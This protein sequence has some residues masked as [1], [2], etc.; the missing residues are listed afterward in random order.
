MASST[1]PP[2]FVK[3]TKSIS[4]YDATSSSSTLG[5][6]D[7]DQDKNQTQP[8]MRHNGDLT[9]HDPPLFVLCTWVAAHPKHIAKYTAAYRQR[10]PRSSVLVI[11]S[12]PMDVIARW[13]DH[14]G[15][16]QFAPA[17][18]IVLQH[19]DA[20][21]ATSNT[22][23]SAASALRMPVLHVVSNG[24]AQSASYLLRALREARPLV[25]TPSTTT[26]ADPTGT[27][28]T[29]PYPSPSAPYFFG[30]VIIDSAPSR[31][32]Y[33]DVA[34]AAATSLGVSGSTLGSA[35]VYGALLPTLAVPNALGL[36]NFVS[37]AADAL[38][39]PIL[40]AP[41]TP[42]LYAYSRADAMIPWRDAQA[43]A[44]ETRASAE[45]AAAAA[46]AVVGEE[47][48]AGGVVVVVEEMVFE[49]TAHCTHAT[50]EPER[51]WKGVVDFLDRTRAAKAKL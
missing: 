29:S 15:L 12:F 16:E 11:Q 44:A 1:E 43:H 4:Y 6:G 49:K 39:D 3:L 27:S 24:G 51:Y 23:S 40:V 32:G 30:S 19:L 10:F 36:G 28:T 45:K 18:D 8:G 31:G 13:T 37:R 34:N 38:R 41:A 7:V 21:A 14:V 35:A 42:R 48:A 50:E 47:G 46:V 20:A 26:T 5:I 17:R 22:T 2:G 9:Y 25:A 33:L